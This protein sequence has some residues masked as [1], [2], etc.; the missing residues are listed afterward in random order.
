LVNVVFLAIWAKV[1]RFILTNLLVF[2]RQIVNF[3]HFGNLPL[4]AILNGFGNID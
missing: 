2:F 4:L 3:D 1:H